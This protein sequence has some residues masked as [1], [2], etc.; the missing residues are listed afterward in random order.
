MVIIYKQ[1]YKIF[2]MKIEEIIQSL[3]RFKPYLMLG[4][5]GYEVTNV[6]DEYLAFFDSKAVYVAS[7][8]GE[9]SYPHCPTLVTAD[10]LL[11]HIPAN[12]INVILVEYRYLA[13]FKEEL[14]KL[15]AS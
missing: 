4:C 15:L 10:I 14:K 1:F 2:F 12:I 5:K 7:E 9:K 11:T 8:Y 3:N 13:K 6:A